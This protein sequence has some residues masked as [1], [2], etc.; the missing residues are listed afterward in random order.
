MS[1]GFAIELRDECRGKE[2]T[3]GKILSGLGRTL[4]GLFRGV[5]S[6]YLAFAA[7]RVLGHNMLL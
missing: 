5:D 6:A 2:P 3:A 7:H 4:G 1:R